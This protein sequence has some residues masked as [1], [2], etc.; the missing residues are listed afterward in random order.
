MF[1]VSRRSRYRFSATGGGECRLRFAAVTALALVPPGA[2]AQE[3]CS[4]YTV[5]EGD[6][7]GEI[8]Q[9]AY[10]SFDY[11]IIFNANR[12]IIGGNP[13]ALEKGTVL[14]IPCEDGR[15]SEQ[16]ELSSIIEAETARQATRTTTTDLYEPPIRFVSG[17][18]WE[19][20]VGE[21]LTGGGFMV[22][23][24]TTALHRGGNNRDYNVSWVNDWNSHKET[25]LPMGAMDVSVAWSIPDCTKV[26]LLSESMVTRCTEWDYSEP[27]YEIV[28]GMYALADSEYAS[29]TT[30]DTYLGSRICRPEGWSIFQLD[31]EGLK[32]P[33]IER[34]APAGVDDC[35]EGLMNG[36]VDAVFLGL[37]IGDSMLQDMGLAQEVVA[38]PY[39][40]K[41]TAIRLVTH[42]TNPRGRVYMTLLNRGLNEM[43]QTGEWYDIVATGL[44]EYNQLQAAN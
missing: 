15:L 34:L 44:A 8:A 3:A 21:N 29:A 33:A 13:N 14:Q 32:P 7:L 20:Y 42:K 9:S 24:A 25:L 30:F 6:T 28:M 22:R 36:T 38:N 2:S 23:L 41:L 43:R 19:P 27:V 26:H 18:G 4:T 16:Q 35:I 37:E 11:Q 40:T 10:G 31:E 17:D 5:R 12:N 1:S 39:L